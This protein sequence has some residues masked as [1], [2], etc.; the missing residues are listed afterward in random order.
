[1]QERRDAQSTG[2]GPCGLLFPGPKSS[3]R[4]LLRSAPLL[5]SATLLTLI[6]GSDRHPFP[7]NK[8][9]SIARTDLKDL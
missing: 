4:H 9:N 3:A 6:H 5:L 8:S 1:M 2:Q 7:M